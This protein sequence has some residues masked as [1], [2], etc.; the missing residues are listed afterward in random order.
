MLRV[1]LNT[2]LTKSYASSP[3]EYGSLGMLLL[4]ALYMF[5]AGLLFLMKTPRPSTESSNDSRSVTNNGE[6]VRT[7]NARSQNSEETSMNAF[8]RELEIIFESMEEG[9]QPGQP[10]S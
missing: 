1:F 6:E 9:G 10:A 2:N 3:F 8:L 7:T 5:V 4:S